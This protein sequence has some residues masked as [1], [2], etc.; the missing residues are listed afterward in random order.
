MP[1]LGSSVLGKL[2]EMDARS[3]SALLRTLSASLM[4]LIFPWIVKMDLTGYPLNSTLLAI[5]Q[6]QRPAHL[7][8]RR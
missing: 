8:P 5:P 3:Y 2:S 4:A 1:L 7:S 6:L